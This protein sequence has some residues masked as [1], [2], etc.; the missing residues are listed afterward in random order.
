MVENHKMMDERQ[1]YY[2]SAY[3]DKVLSKNNSISRST[4]EHLINPFNE[5]SSSNLIPS[6]FSGEP[7]RPY[8]SYP[9]YTDFT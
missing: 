6:R 9:A 5:T 8:S 3:N 2:G 4:V 1:N 7:S